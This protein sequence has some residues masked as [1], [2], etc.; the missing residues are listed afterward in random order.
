MA[1]RRPTHDHSGK[2]LPMRVRQP[3]AYWTIMIV[4]ALMVLSLVA[5]AIPLL[6]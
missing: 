2:I 6:F 4:S 5:S 3:F 1:R